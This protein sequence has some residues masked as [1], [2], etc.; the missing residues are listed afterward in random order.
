MIT[1]TLQ[2]GSYVRLAS[3]R[4]TTYQVVSID[5]NSDCCWVRRWPLS[6]QGSPPFAIPLHQVIEMV[7][8]WSAT[9]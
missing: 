6:R 8:E 3:S 1:M 7:E 5:E 2:P 9:A 4:D